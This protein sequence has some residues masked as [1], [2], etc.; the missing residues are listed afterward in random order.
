MPRE[1][2]APE[3]F[4]HVRLELTGDAVDDWRRGYRPDIRKPLLEHAQAKEMVAVAVRD[5]DVGQVLSAC[6][7]LVGELD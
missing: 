6:R 4:Q 5:V 3:A 2:R 1:A 7:H